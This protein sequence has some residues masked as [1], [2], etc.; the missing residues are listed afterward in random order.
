VRIGEGLR[1][2][3]TQRLQAIKIA[4]EQCDAVRRIGLRCAQGEG[5]EESEK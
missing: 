4:I 2:I 5:E 3:R 1:K